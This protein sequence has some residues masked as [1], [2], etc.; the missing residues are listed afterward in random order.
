MCRSEFGPGSAPFFC[1]ATTGS[2]TGVPKKINE[3]TGFRDRAV[4]PMPECGHRLTA[5]P[6]HPYRC[7]T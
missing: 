1:I 7:I 5:N 2:A 6:F 3:N 4:I